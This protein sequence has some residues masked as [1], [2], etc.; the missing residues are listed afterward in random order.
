M[1]DAPPI[2]EGAPP[3]DEQKRLVALFD[4]LEKKQVEFLDQA[5][6]RVVELCTALLGVF[7]GVLAFGDKFPPPYLD[8]SLPA[9]ILTLGT[10]VFYIAAMLASL[11]AVQPREYRRYQHNLTEMRKELANIISFKSRWVKVAGMLFFLGT[12]WLALLIVAIVFG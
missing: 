7:F 12:V 3:T 6:K 4:E 8:G 10:L 9:Q 1:S 5:G 2:Y 11:Y